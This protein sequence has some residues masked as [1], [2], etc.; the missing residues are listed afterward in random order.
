MARTQPRPL[1]RIQALP[2]WLTGRVAARGRARLTEAI[3]KEDLN[4]AHLAVLAA[5]VQAAPLAQADLVRRLT[6]DAKD[7][8]LLINHLEHLGHVV[9][10]PDPRDRRKN[11]IRVTPQGSA[12]LNR[13]LKE[14]ER[15][16]AELL[17]PLEDGE[18]RQLLE[19]L[20]RVLDE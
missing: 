14:A 20:G 13:C 8:V 11:V 12:A 16:N 9:R 6:I 3:A 15:V 17:A 5:A 1:D 19:L 7:M 18:R 4:L 10:D 2:S